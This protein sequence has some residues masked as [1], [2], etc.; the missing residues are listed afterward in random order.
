M[1]DDGAA[2]PGTATTAGPAKAEP[3]DHSLPGTVAPGAAEKE[4]FPAALLPLPP[5]AEAAEAGAA[6]AAAAALAAAEDAVDGGDWGVLC[7][8][9]QMLPLKSA[10]TIT[11]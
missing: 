5:A 7:T 9:K 4:A 3:A 10:A 11:I 2:W 1:E 6:A 8:Y